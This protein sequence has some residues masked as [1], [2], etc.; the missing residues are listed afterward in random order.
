MEAIFTVPVV[1]LLLAWKL[2]DDSV[3]ALAAAADPLSSSGSCLE[4]SPCILLPTH[5]SLMMA[6]VW[7]SL[8]SQLSY[9]PGLFYGP[10]GN[11]FIQFIPGWF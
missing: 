8:G 9:F 10:G 5:L 2:M 3:N 11:S 6:E 1:W 7:P 4:R